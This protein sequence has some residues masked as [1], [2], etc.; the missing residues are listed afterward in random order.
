MQISFYLGNIPNSISTSTILSSN[1]KEMH[2]HLIVISN[3]RYSKKE[4]R[5]ALYRLTPETH[6]NA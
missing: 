3:S 6:T 1:S 5:L 4:I 2:S